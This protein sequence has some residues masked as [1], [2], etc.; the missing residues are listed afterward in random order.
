MAQ[1]FWIRAGERVRGPFST[2]DVQRLA[3][4]GRLNPQHQLSVDQQT[5]QPAG[6]VPGLQ[7]AESAV[8]PKGKQSISNSALPIKPQP[9]WVV[10]G[11]ALLVLLT[12]GVAAASGWAF[13][14]LAG[15]VSTLLFMMVATIGL[16]AVLLGR[17]ATV[18]YA[19]VASALGLLTFEDAGWYGASA[20]QVNA[21]LEN[22]MVFDDPDTAGQPAGPQEKPQTAGDSPESESEFGLDVWL[23][24]TAGVMIL[25]LVGSAAV[26]VWIRR[27]RFVGLLE[28]LIVFGA[29]GLFA[30]RVILMAASTPFRMWGMMALAAIPGLIL[31]F[32]WWLIL[33]GRGHDFAED[34]GLLR[35]IA[36][37]TR[38]RM[39]AGDVRK[40]AATLTKVAG[41]AVTAV[42]AG[43]VKLRL[44]PDDLIRSEDSLSEVLQTEAKRGVPALGV[45]LA[46]H[47]VLL[48]VLLFFHLQ[49]KPI[50]DF[51]IEGGFI[52]EADRTAVKPEVPVEPPP[53][54]LQNASLNP[55][56]VPENKPDDTAE[57]NGPPK[58][59]TPAVPTANVDNIL[60]DRGEAERKAVLAKFAE[61]EKIDFAVRSG[62]A[63]LQRQQLDDGRWQLHTGYPNAGEAVLK[64][65][66][67]ATALALLTFLGHGQTH[68][69]ADND[70]FQ[71][72]VQK[73]LD[74]LRSVQK[75]DGDFHDWD[76]LGRQTAYY[77]HSQAVIVFCEAY[78]LTKDRSL[79]EPARKGVK[80][81]LASQQPT[82]GGWK[83]QPQNATSVG[84]LSVT[85]WALMALHSARTAGIGVP[86]A[87]FNRAQGFLD[88]VQEADGA[89][90]RY[91]PRPGWSPTV[92][93]TAVG[94]LCRQYFG[95]QEGHPALEDG[96][97]WMLEDAHK[98]EW[99]T[100]KRNVYEWYYVAQVLH[101]RNDERFDAW[102]QHTA[103]EII[104]KQATAGPSFRG[105][106]H[107]SNPQGATYEYGE[108]TGR[109]YVTCM[110]LLTL[111]TPYRHRS[112]SE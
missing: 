39:G 74:W 22:D 69:N 88:E 4:E 76:E 56:A 3:R 83:Y 35:G 5:W 36:E 107:P 10:G 93:M 1:Q 13:G 79:L 103:A 16:A 110:C 87:A 77:S 109:L 45:S 32:A 26:T 91:E 2:E 105:S 86:S 65:D 20:Q 63:W 40:A 95:W 47:V 55:V 108:K 58:G 17:S 41:T 44:D 102:Y 80:F 25:G 15:L 90:Y 101:N 104:S 7:F 70:R 6:D 42:P 48:G 106:W 29:L 38:R 24:L 57:P 34:T 66:T 72:C 14:P 11:W 89:R 94:L 59:D 97:A 23:A 75:P 61:G 54:V 62:L 50:N 84:D 53:V 19:L 8:T 96:I 100:G 99:A 51:V 18:I 43:R 30:F 71:E 68:E 78:A 81:L 46:L 49:P 64:T 92:A 9:A 31:V 67:G 12:V 60:A 82:Q 85:G 52:T 73:G 98:P 21:N 37:K 27:R 28:Q 111:E 33:R 112:L